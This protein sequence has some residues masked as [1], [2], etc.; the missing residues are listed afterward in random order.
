MRVLRDIKRGA[1]QETP[2]PEGE[3]KIRGLRQK[4]P[5]AGGLI[6]TEPVLPG[7]KVRGREMSAKEVLRGKKRRR[8]KLF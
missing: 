1:V 8:A 2:P 7:M 6:P 5:R 4:R 3:A